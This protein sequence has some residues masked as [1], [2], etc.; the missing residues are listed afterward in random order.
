MSRTACS[1]VIPSGI[2]TTAL[3]AAG[4]ATASACPPA[5][6]SEVPNTLV[7]AFRHTP[8]SPARQAEQRPQPITP[9]T[10]TRSPLP[11]VVT[12]L[13]DVLDG[14]HELVPEVHPGDR[15]RPVVQV[16][17][18]AADGRAVDPQQQPVRSRHPC[19]GHVLD[20]DVPLPVQHDSTH[21]GG[22]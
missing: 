2:L 15:H 12:A 1:S 17:V 9:D 4:T 5:S 7:P 18:A 22:P 21:G 3:S 6:S 10:I 16:Q 20:G 13:P 19:I 11:T 14:A 8:T